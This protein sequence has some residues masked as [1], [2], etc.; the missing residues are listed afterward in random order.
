MELSKN[1]HIDKCTQHLCVLLTLDRLSSATEATHS[2][3]A[4]EVNI[5]HFCIAN[6]ERSVLWFKRTKP[7]I[8]TG[9][10]FTKDIFVWSLSAV[11]PSW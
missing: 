6:V 5:S 10:M 7:V 11:W 2:F 8:W 4:T 9:Q 3:F 1:Y